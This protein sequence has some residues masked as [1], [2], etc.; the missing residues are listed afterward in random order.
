MSQLS[1]ALKKVAAI[2]SSTYLGEETEK[3]SQ[4]SGTYKVNKWKVE[5]SF[6]GRRYTCPLYKTGEGLRKKK[7]SFNSK[8]GQ[9]GNFPVAGSNHPDVADVIHCLIT[10]THCGMMAFDEYCSEFG[11][12]TDSRA[13]FKVWEQCVETA[14]PFRRFLGSEFDHLSMLEH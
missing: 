14:G 1:E 5:L 3:Y 11:L 4:G 8:L 6:Q 2:A 12:D 7:Y 13:A 10:D 9:W